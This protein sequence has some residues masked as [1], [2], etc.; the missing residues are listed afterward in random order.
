MTNQRNYVKMDLEF[1]AEGISPAE[2]MV[3]FNDFLQERTQL[4]SRSG[5]TTDIQI[6]DSE[7]T[8]IV[9][10]NEE[11]IEREFL[12]EK[13]NLQLTDD[14]LQMAINQGLIGEAL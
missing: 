3:Y 12:D 11:E 10:I 2:L 1:L 8:S 5:R 14:E 6:L 7:I 13:G 4:V 9:Q